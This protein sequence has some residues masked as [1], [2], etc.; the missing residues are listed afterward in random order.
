MNNREIYLEPIPGINLGNDED[1]KEAE[2]KLNSNQQV[3][4]EQNKTQEGAGT[5]TVQKDSG[6]L[7]DEETQEKLRQFKEKIMK[8]KNN[9]S[10]NSINLSSS[11]LFLF[12]SFGLIDDNDLILKRYL[13]K[14]EDNKPFST[15][16]LMKY[17]ESTEID[18]TKKLFGYNNKTVKNPVKEGLLNKIEQLR[19]NQRLIDMQFKFDSG[20]YLKKIGALEKACNMNYDEN[21]LKQLE[22]INKENKETIKQYK[23][24]IEQKE[25][26]KIKDKKNFY[27][28]LNEIID[29][30]STLMA[31]LKE[32]EILAKNTSFQDYDEYLR[33]NPTK[34]DKLNFRAND[35]RYLLTNEYETSR[36]E[37]SYSSY[38]KLNHINN[39]PEGFDINKQNN[40]FDK[41][42]QYFFNTKNFVGT[43]ASVNNNNNNNINNSFNNNRV[44]NSFIINNNKSN[45]KDLLVNYSFKKKETFNDI[46][47]RKSI[48]EINRNNTK[49]KGASIFNKSQNQNQNQ[50]KINKTQ[51]NSS[52]STKRINPSE[53]FN[54]RTPQDPDFLNNDMILMRDMKKDDPFY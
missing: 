7:I 3:P 4:Q 38:E 19:R 28:A 14:D 29:L 32:L 20:I 50:P 8:E 33:D 43:V 27:N 26:E 25:K 22:K 39:T 42:E 48:S 46:K 16:K 17:D 36:E 41:T 31:E 35:S 11:L 18:N 54:N 6:Q 37:E 44:N 53:F 23:K 30:K 1:K 51:N 24:S 5:S 12:R 9:Y 40:N 49:M 47:S 2:S 13:L 15:K 45:N 52:N 21:K 34:I 10:R